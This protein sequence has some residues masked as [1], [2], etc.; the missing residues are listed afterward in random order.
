M[1]SCLNMTTSLS[2]LTLFASNG[3]EA[4]GGYCVANLRA[5]LRVGIAT[6]VAVAVG[7]NV[8]PPRRM[9]TAE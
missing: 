6:L 1:D 8:N 7:K 4:N 9:D 3:S 5:G 2:C